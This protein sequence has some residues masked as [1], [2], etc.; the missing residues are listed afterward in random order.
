MLFN[1]IGL[2]HGENEE[3][4]LAALSMFKDLVALSSREHLLASSQEPNSYGS[5]EELVWMAWVQ[6]EIRRRTGYCIWVCALTAT[7]HTSYLTV[8]GQLLDCSIVYYFNDR[9]LLSLDD[10]QAPL[11]AHEDLWQAGDAQAWRQLWNQSKGTFETKFR[12]RA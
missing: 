3:S 1:S 5:S 7:Q 4:Q 6:D 8:K 12:K 10:G 2:L 11:P 9:P